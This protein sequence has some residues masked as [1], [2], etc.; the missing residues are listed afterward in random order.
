[1]CFSSEPPRD[2]SA[3]IARQQADERQG[4]IRQGQQQIDRQFGV[5]DAPYYD[6]FKKD[7]TDY[8]N[9]QVDEQFGDAKQKLTYNLA[10][11]GTRDSSGGQKQFGDLVEAYGQQ[12][13]GVANKAIQGASAL[14]GQVEQSKS[15]LYSQNTA[16]ADPALAGISAST[17]AGALQSPGVYSPIGDL[18][19]GLVNSGGAYLKGVQQGLPAGYGGAFA[20]GQNARNNAVRVTG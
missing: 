12:R 16:A 10:R 7:Y 4:A 9:P 17:R 6:K 11:T 1:M 8:Y 18:F 3:T 5:F 14:R 19:G 15:D 2:N 13:E 20:P